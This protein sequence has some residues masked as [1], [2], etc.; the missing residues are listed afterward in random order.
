VDIN[1]VL[2]TAVRLLAPQM[3]AESSSIRLDLTPSLPMV[4]ADSNQILHV[5]M[6][7]AGQINARLD[8]QGHSTLIIRT[9]SKGSLVMVDFLSLDPSADPSP[10]SFASLLT[11]EGANR[12]S[13][14]SLSACCRIVE[15][16]GGRLLQPEAS[17]NSAFRM[18]LRVAAASSRP[19]YTTARAAARSSS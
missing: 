17:A 16:H 5:C 14:L 15:E 11:S 7:L 8:R 19:S 13:T 1:S 9:H 2:Q 12:P 3:E 18:E 4:I 10:V 6:H